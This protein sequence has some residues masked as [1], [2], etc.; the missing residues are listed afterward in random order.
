MAEKNRT[1]VK[2]GAKE[3][4]IVSEESSEYVNRVAFDLNR[5]LKEVSGSCIGMSSQMI[6]TLTALNMADELMK[7]K[8]A[9]KNAEASVASLTETVHDLQIQEN[10]R[11][12]DAEKMRRQIDALE[13]EVKKLRAAEPALKG[14]S[15]RVTNLG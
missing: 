11:K 12:E 9:L 7:A 2:I 14:R 4:T 10:V 3:Y 13:A 6:T 15:N 1:V 5:R 8:E